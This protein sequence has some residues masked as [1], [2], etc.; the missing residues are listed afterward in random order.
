MTMSGFHP[1][2]CRLNCGRTVLRL[3][4]NTGP[5]RIFYLV[6]FSVRTTGAW[7]S[8]TSCHVT[9]FASASKIT[10]SETWVDGE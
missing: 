4:A 3:P 10:G 6:E 2:A 9:P 7:D 1:I 8:P 5:G